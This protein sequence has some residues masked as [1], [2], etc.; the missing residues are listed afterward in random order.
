M[1]SDFAKKIQPGKRF[2]DSAADDLRELAGL[3]DGLNVL[4]DAKVSELSAELK[5]LAKV[6]PGD[7][8]DDDR[9]RA[10]TIEK[11]DAIR[12]KASQVG[13]WF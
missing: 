6:E 9:E 5:A 7:L 10:K 8:R 4:G 2:W 13:A 1:A 12:K 11:A 3:I